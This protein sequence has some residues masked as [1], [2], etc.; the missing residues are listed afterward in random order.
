MSLLFEFEPPKKSIT[1]DIKA[2][3]SAICEINTDSNYFL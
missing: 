3:L 1:L 2:I